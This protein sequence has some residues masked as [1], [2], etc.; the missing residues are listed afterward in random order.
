MQ[1][2]GFKLQLQPGNGFQGVLGFAAAARVPDL[3]QLQPG[4]GFQGVLG[5]ADR[6][7]GL[8][9][10]RLSSCT[11]INGDEGLAAALDKLTAGLEHLS[12]EGLSSNEAR[13]CFPTAVLERLQQLTYL[14]LAGV[15]VQR[16][17]QATPTLQPLQALTRR[18]AS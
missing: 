4:D 13:T 7:A 12:I 18:P 17:D 8:K 2:K 9:Q 5:A 10:L 1:V 11:L 14:E 6:A 3:K 16:P 15:R